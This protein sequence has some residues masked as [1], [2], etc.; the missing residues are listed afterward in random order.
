MTY[1]PT[2]G[3]QKAIAIL[4]DELSE[5]QSDQAYVT[6]EFFYD[7]QRAVK[8]ARRN[9]FGVFEEERDPQTGRKKIFIPFTEW[10]V[11]TV[12]K[13]IDIDTKDIEV[14]AKKPDS[15]KVAQIFRYVLRYYLN[16]IHFGKKLN[17]LLRSIVID[18]TAF[19]K[20]W[21]ESGE[22]KLRVVDRLN[23]TVDPTAPNLD[24]TPVIER[25]LLTLPEFKA[26]DWNN[27]EEVKGSKSLD[28]TGLD[29]QGG[30]NTQIPYVE[31]YERYGYF[32]KFVFTENEK[33][34]DYVYG[35]VCYSSNGNSYIVHKMEE[36]K[37]HP[38]QEF[39]FRDLVNRFDGR[40]VP[41]VL[42][43]IQTYLNEIINIRLNTARIAQAG[44]WEVRGNI[45]P[46]QLKR[47]FST[48]AIKTSQEGDITRLDTGTVDP[49]SYKDEEQAYLWGQ[50]VTQ[51]QITDEQAAQQPATNALIQERGTSKGYNLIMEGIFLNLKKVLEEKLIPIIRDTIKNGEIVRITGSVDALRELDRELAKAVIY[52][53]KEKEFADFLARTPLTSIDDANAAIQKF[54]QEQEMEIEKLATEMAQYGEDRFPELRKDLFNTEFDIDIE[55]GDEQIN[56]GVMVNQ[57]IQAMNILGG[58]GMPVDG[59]AREIFDTLGLD[60]EKMVQKMQ[61]QTQQGKSPSESLNYKDAPPDI[62]RQIEAQAGL[63]PSQNPVM[64]GTTGQPMQATQQNPQPATQGMPTEANLSPTPV[65]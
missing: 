4:K 6:D 50:R 41:E 18:G 3:E 31:V 58:L 28:R 27:K 35:K 46:Q 61:P 13:N 22:M 59:V 54:E 8:R 34:E 37:G 49:S 30:Q 38:Y 32:P 47:L 56:K 43:Q 53:K 23:M 55:I 44:L 48:G 12:L 52:E 19:L 29:M 26:Y 25:N 51:T 10:T 7:G 9:Y 1:Q 39:K 57:L 63:Q 15:Y 65:R 5:W 62:Q 21:K 33:D 60:A 20:V 36:T 45:T 17:D 42:F 11:E 40:G 64:P 16:K 14:K 24:E 2:T